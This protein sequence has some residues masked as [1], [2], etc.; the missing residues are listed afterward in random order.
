[1]NVTKENLIE[2]IKM[3]LRHITVAHDCYMAYKTLVNLINCAE[4][5]PKINYAPMFFSATAHALLDSLQMEL[6][7]LYC[8]TQKDEKSLM[9]LI[10][11]VEGNAKVFPRQVEHWSN[12]EDEFS[13]I[14]TEKTIEDVDILEFL[15][16][17]RNN[18][19]KL[20]VVIQNLKRRRDK[21]IAHNDKVYFFSQRELYIDSVLTMNDFYTLIHFAGDFCNKLLSY[22]NVAS[23]KYN[24]SRTEDLKNLLNKCIG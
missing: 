8:Y 19:I 1:M 11:K 6:S 21:K 10:L 4:T 18:L 7:K 20:D 2:E 16:E 13:D 23:V 17:T 24:L 22:L 3:Y 15:S 5:N 12:T 9:K 14:P